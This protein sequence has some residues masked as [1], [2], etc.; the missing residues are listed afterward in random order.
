MIGGLSCNMQWKSR[1]KIAGFHFYGYFAFCG[2]YPL[3]NRNL[4]HLFKI[5]IFN[6]AVAFA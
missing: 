5:S 3:N 4:F 1:R 2:L 6:R